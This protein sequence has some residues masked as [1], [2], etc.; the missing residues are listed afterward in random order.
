MAERHTVTFRSLSG[1]AASATEEDLRQLGLKVR[2]FAS[3]A[4][5]SRLP[6]VP[7]TSVLLPKVPFQSFA[8]VPT[9]EVDLTMSP[10]R[11]AS[12]LTARGGNDNPIGKGRLV[13]AGVP[14]APAASLAVSMTNM[15]VVSEGAEG[16]EERSPVVVV[17]RLALPAGRKA[18]VNDWF[19]HTGR[20]RYATFSFSLV[21]PSISTARQP[22]H[23]GG[24]DEPQTMLSNVTRQSNAARALE[25]AELRQTE[26][27]KKLLD[28]ERQRGASSDTILEKDVFDRYREFLFHQQP[29]G[30]S[31]SLL[32]PLLDYRDLQPSPALLVPATDSSGSSSSSAT[33]HTLPSLT[34]MAEHRRQ[35]KRGRHF[36]FSLNERAELLRAIQ[37]YN[38][39]SGW[40]W[41]GVVGRNVFCRFVVNLEL[42]GLETSG[43]LWSEFI[44]RFLWVAWV[45]DAHATIIHVTRPHLVIMQRGRSVLTKAQFLSVMAEVLGHLMQ[46]IQSRMEYFISYHLKRAVQRVAPSLLARSPTS[47]HPL[48]DHQDSHTPQGLPPAAAKGR[49]GDR[50]GGTIRR[51]GSPKDK[52]SRKRGTK[53]RRDPEGDPR[54]TQRPDKRMDAARHK[55]M[56][57]KAIKD[58]PKAG[59][60]DE[61]VSTVP[62]VRIFRHVRYMLLEPEVLV[63]CAALLPI[64]KRLFAV[65]TAMPPK[66]SG[67][68]QL[69]DSKA[70][71][72][73]D[74]SMLGHMTQREFV[75]F[76]VDFDIIP[77]LCHRS[78]AAEIYN[79]SQCLTFV[80]RRTSSDI[81]VAPRLHRSATDSNVSLDYLSTHAIDEETQKDDQA[82]AAAAADDA[83][84]PPPST[85]PQQKRS[86]MVITGTQQQEAP[87]AL[88]T[89]PQPTSKDNKKALGA[90]KVGAGGRR[91]TG[92]DERP[93]AV[94]RG[95][96]DA[97]P[98]KKRA[99][100]N[101]LNKRFAVA[102]LM[103]TVLKIAFLYLHHYSTQPQMASSSYVKVVWLYTFLLSRIHHVRQLQQ[104]QGAA[105]DPRSSRAGTGVTG[106]AVMGKREVRSPKLR[107][108]ASQ[109][110]I[111]ELDALVTSLIRQKLAIQPSA[112][113]APSPSI[114]PTASYL[115]LLKSA[116]PSPRPPP[117]VSSSSSLSHLP[118]HFSLSPEEFV[119]E[120]QVEARTLEALM[121]R[122][123]QSGAG[124]GGG[125]GGVSPVSRRQK[126]GRGSSTATVGDLRLFVGVVGSGIEGAMNCKMGAGEKDAVLMPLV[127]ESST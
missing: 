71:G 65:Y 64:F 6:P 101:K 66:E 5:P 78:R 54:A 42:P 52:E 55:V 73:S 17:P 34:D 109:P 94:G 24:V 48:T 44:D 126:G 125:G 14:P 108:V 21:L 30:F 116:R 23:V 19:T 22:I 127:A 122:V 47:S 93:P 87:P 9:R 3:L 13:N 113:D 106:S 123:K 88:P 91:Q 77:R 115:P 46:P 12:F 16:E 90:A 2:P 119:W 110:E 100:V 7:I 82:A 15:S 85:N 45:F 53:V 36:D 98:G 43:Q 105:S 38:Q 1:S 59:A 56:G 97:P 84:T 41:E 118:Q 75:V 102:S 68:A 18:K 63:M 72:W 11:N 112:R 121:A 4:A 61:T 25:A 33:M 29:Q 99:D 103:E 69:T 96:A 49:M 28:L 60:D 95:V 31:P 83:K 117:D 67:G 62:T 120:R 27:R 79:D 107:E 74:A 80:E 124:G 104:H 50:E 57:V 32:P 92:K 37:W 10:S 114:S 26:E 86:S 8:S 81:A 35:R 76:C 89:P 20:K 39:A 51:R 70:S 58:A 40:Q 111:F